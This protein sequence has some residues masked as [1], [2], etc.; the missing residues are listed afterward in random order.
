MIEY[1][2]HT[3]TGYLTILALT[4][5]LLFIA[6]LMA[7]DGFNWV[8]FAVLIILSACLG[9]FSTLTVVI[10]EEFLEVWFGIGLFRKK[11]L[12]K[13]IRSCRVVKNLWYYGWGIRL[14]PYGWL[15]NVSGFYAVEIEMFNGKKYRI[16]SDVPNE[17]ER[18]IRQSIERRSSGD[19]WK[20]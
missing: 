14:T 7:I 17:L 5:A 20:V 9:L 19:R 18:A 16:G 1:Y 3:Q 11:F 8:A 13:D 4:I 6:Y 10:K 15:Y 2:H 12:L